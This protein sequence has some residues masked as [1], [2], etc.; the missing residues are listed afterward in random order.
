MLRIGCVIC[1]YQ[2]MVFISTIIGRIFMRPDY[3]AGTIIDKRTGKVLG[4]AS[5]EEVARHRRM[6]LQEV[7]AIPLRDTYWTGGGLLTIF[8]AP[9]IGIWYDPV[10]KIGETSNMYTGRYGWDFFLA[11]PLSIRVIILLGTMAITAYLFFKVSAAVNNEEKI[12]FCIFVFI[13]NVIEAVLAVGNMFTD[14]LLFIM[15]YLVFFEI[16]LAAITLVILHGISAN[17]IG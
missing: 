7:K 11:M 17:D 1:Y 8:L 10:S 12:G 5:R 3:D 15:P 2:L 16:V 6:D 9:I 14:K 4:P 13:T